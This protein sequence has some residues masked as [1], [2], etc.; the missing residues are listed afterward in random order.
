LLPDRRGSEH[1]PAGLAWAL[2]GVVAAIFIAGAAG[3][4]LDDRAV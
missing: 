4:R 1:C 2:M 3:G